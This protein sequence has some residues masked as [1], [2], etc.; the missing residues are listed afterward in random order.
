MNPSNLKNTN[1]ITELYFMKI[2]RQQFWNTYS[3]SLDSMPLILTLLKKSSLPRVL[4]KHFAYEHIIL[5]ANSKLRINLQGSVVI[6]CSGK[7]RWLPNKLNIALYTRTNFRNGRESI[8]AY[9]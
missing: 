1:S 8:V 3:K 2:C 5:M 4:S 7:S 6:I 9:S